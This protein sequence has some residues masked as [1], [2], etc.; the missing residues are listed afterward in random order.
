M[1]AS[2]DRGFA[3]IL[4]SVDHVRLVCRHRG[5]DLKAAFE[6][7]C[8][9]QSGLEP[10]LRRLG[11][12]FAKSENLGFLTTCPS[13]LGSGVQITVTAKLP[14]LSASLE[15][16]TLCKGLGLVARP[17]PLETSAFLGCKARYLDIS[18]VEQLGSSAAEQVNATIEG[19]RQLVEREQQLELEQGVPLAAA[20]AEQA[21]P[22]SAPGAED[23][24][25]IRLHVCGLS[26]NDL[27]TYAV[28]GTDTVADLLKELPLDVPESKEL[29]CLHGGQTLAA[30]SVLSRSDVT[31]GATLTVV[32]VD[33]VGKKQEAAGKLQSFWKNRKR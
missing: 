14:L 7:L 4:N 19:C 24:E 15:F 28:S 16:K 11:H 13:L 12:E 2:F 32:M 22:D 27:G 1:F 20:E 5:S 18:L 25:T 17:S 3:A 9:A 21:H 10:E 23:G 33:V 8:A 6:R 31:T 26:G 30:T 29:T